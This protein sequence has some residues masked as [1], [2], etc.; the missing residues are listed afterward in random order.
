MA[1]D[2]ESL[3]DAKENQR[4]NIATT[5]NKEETAYTIVAENIVK[6]FGHVVRRNSL[7]RLT[8]EGMVAGRR[9]RGRSPTRYAD[10]ITNITEKSS[11][12]I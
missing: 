6:F 10:L 7:E 5:K 8:I 1:Q 3:M 2:A 11:M 12:L 4:I 9:S